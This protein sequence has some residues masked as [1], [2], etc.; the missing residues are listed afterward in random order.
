MTSILSSPPYVTHLS[1]NRD[2]TGTPVACSKC[3]ETFKTESDYVIHYNE[4][5][6][7]IGSE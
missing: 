6:A 3:N 7:G 2:D 1:E 5:H 4:T